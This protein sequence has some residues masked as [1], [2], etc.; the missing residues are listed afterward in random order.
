MMKILMS[1][2]SCGPGQGSEPDVGWHWALEAAR[3]GHDVTVLT[4]THYK[5]QIEQEIASGTLPKN[6]HFDIFM[7]ATL[8]ALW[9]AG[10]RGQWC[11]NELCQFVHLAWQFAALRHVRR[12][13][14]IADFDLVHHVT[15]ATIRHPTLLGRLGLPM[16]LGPVG[17]GG[18]VPIRLRKSFDWLAWCTEL[19]RDA[20]TLALRADP[21]TYAACRQADVLFVRDEDSRRRLP[22]R[23]RDK[24]IVQLGVGV[25][26]PDD[27]APNP[28]CPGDPLRLIFAGRLLYLKG[29]HLGIRALASARSRGVDATLTVVGDGPA[30]RGIEELAR[31]LGV[32]PYLTWCGRIPQSDLFSMYRSHDAL[33]FPSL[34]DSAGLTVLESLCRGLPV[35]GLALGGTAGMVNHTCGRVV[36]VEGLEE[37]ACV[38]GLANAITELAT[39]EG[40]S[41]RLSRGAIARAKDYSWPLVVARVY[42]EIEKEFSIS[43]RS[44]PQTA[45]HCASSAL[46]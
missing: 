6:L 29:L 23:F 5:D 40:L 41:V 10:L 17:G 42:A 45:G 7:P 16:V 25:E 27:S 30:R 43:L 39:A 46:A 44:G 34:R 36:E 4:Q 18:R 9:N 35:I 21:I 24:T 3:R 19:I 2:F 22:R 20:H 38:A 15:Y 31:D 8:E 11:L 12:N 33:L 32:D 13:Y 28:R 26:A 1:A 14:R 37:G